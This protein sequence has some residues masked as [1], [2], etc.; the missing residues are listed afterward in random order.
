MESTDPLTSRHQVKQGFE[1]PIF[2]CHFHGWNPNLWAQNKTYKQYLAQ[3]ESGTSTVQEELEQYGRKYPY[4]QLKGTQ[5]PGGVDATSKEVHPHPSRYLSTTSLPPLP[6]PLIPSR[7]SC[8]TMN[9]M[10]C[11]T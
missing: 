3:V 10:V 9:S 2:A 11:L 1:P 7:C 6:S 8:L 5:C 4:A